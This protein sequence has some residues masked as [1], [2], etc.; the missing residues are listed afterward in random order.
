[1]GRLIKNHWGRLIVLTAAAYQVGAAIEGFFW[2][3]IF[4]DFL[5]KKFD[6]VVKP[7]P[8][9]QTINLLLGM[10]MLMLEWPLSIMTR[11][12]LYNSLKLRLILLPIVAFTS[13]L[14]Y[15]STNPAIYYLIGMAVYLMA[16]ND[17]ETICGT[18]WS[19][20]NNYA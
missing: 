4:W 8:I 5:T 3:K 2:P 6:L 20:P 14:M 12:S 17:G 7:V 16:Y 9:L 13:L 18:P 15:Q 11:L 10:G 19:V 1:M